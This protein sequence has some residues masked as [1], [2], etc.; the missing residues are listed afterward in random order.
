MISFLHISVTKL[1]FVLLM[2]FMKIIEKETRR[3]DDN[4]VLHFL[5]EVRD[6]QFY[7]FR[8]LS[9]KMRL[10][11]RESRSIF[12]EWDKPKILLKLAKRR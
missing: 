6:A 7:N 8:K 3:Q 5:W 12:M 10:N 2:M 9:H 4:E 1:I 11:L